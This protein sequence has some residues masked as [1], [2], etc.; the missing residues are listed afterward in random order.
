MKIREIVGDSTAHRGTPEFIGLDEE[1]CPS[2]TTAIG[3]LERW[4]EMKVHKEG[5]KH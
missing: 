4:F 3:Q 1:Q 2:I 5:E